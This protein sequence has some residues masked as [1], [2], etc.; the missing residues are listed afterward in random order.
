M[1][2]QRDAQKQSYLRAAMEN[3]GILNSYELLFEIPLQVGV[4][5]WVHLDQIM[6]Q[7]LEQIFLSSSNI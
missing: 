5:D 6:D 3:E 2:S 1:V 7:I 4:L